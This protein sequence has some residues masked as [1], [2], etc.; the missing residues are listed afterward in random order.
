MRVHIFIKLT[1]NYPRF[2][3]DFVSQQDDLLKLWSTH[4]WL[5]VSG[6]KTLVI[7]AASKLLLTSQ[8]QPTDG[9]NENFCG[10]SFNFKKVSLKPKILCKITPAARRLPM[11]QSKGVFE[12]QCPAKDPNINQILTNIHLG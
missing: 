5:F 3:L 10:Q 12:S 9:P 6:P 11:R 8:A 2:G 4:G 1:R 7:E